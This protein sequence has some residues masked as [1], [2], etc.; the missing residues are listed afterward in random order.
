MEMT[1]LK[2]FNTQTYDVNY[3]SKERT[4]ASS[5]QCIVSIPMAGELGGWGLHMDI[6]PNTAMGLVLKQGPHQSLGHKNTFH[7]CRYINPLREEI[8]YKTTKHVFVSL[9]FMSHSRPLM[10][11]VSPQIVGDQIVAI[12]CANFDEEESHAFMA[13]H[14]TI[15]SVTAGPQLTEAHCAKNP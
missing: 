7:L 11:T 12:I 9:F 15:I 6:F 1:H 3:H 13:A 10:N 4:F 8:L 14:S 2:E 5:M